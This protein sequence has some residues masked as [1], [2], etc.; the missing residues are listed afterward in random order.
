MGEKKFSKSDGSLDFSSRRIR[1]QERKEKIN[2]VFDIN[3]F[4]ISG[5]CVYLSVPFLLNSDSL[6]KRRRKKRRIEEQE[7][8]RERA[9]HFFG[10]ARMRARPFVRYRLFF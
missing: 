1:T 10:Y 6:I 9:I 5:A 4:M 3:C 8:E 2:F 7:R